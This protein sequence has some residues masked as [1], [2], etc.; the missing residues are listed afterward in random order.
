MSK[1]KERDK[2]YLEEILRI[3]L[4]CKIATFPL[5]TMLFFYVFSS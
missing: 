4:V 3:N 5:I 2:F 1:K